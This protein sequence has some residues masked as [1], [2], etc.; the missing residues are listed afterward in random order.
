MANGRWWVMGDIHGA[1]RGMIQCF[2]RCGFQ[3]Q[4]DTLVVLG[5]V[6]DGWS[7]VGRSIDLLLSIPH[8]HYVL[9]NHDY[10]ALRWARNQETPDMWLQQGGQATIDSLPSGNACTTLELFAR[11]TPLLSESRVVCLYTPG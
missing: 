10:W 6:C 3:P 7:E 5:D 11:S 9:G 8:L 2:E 4:S 1:Y